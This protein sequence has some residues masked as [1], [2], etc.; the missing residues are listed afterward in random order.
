M[1]L[2]FGNYGNGIEEMQQYFSHISGAIRFEYMKADLLMAQEDLEKYVGSAVM[3]EA[4]NHYHTG[5][6]NQPLSNP[7]ASGSGSAADSL[8]IKDGLV[9]H[10]QMAVALMGYRDYALNNDATHT[11]TGRLARMDKE[12]GDEW[13]EKLIDRDDFALQRKAQRAIDRLIKYVDDNEMES[14]RNSD[15]YADTKELLLW[16]ATLFHRFHPIEYSRRL[17]MLLVPMIRSVQRDMVEPIFGTERWT[18][19]MTRMKAN[20][21]KGDGEGEE[22]LRPLYDKAGYVIAYLA[23]S[24]GYTDL[25]L[26]LFP[27]TMSRQFWSAGSGSAFVTFRQRLIDGLKEEGIHKLKLL[28]NYIRA[29]ETKDEGEDVTDDTMTTSIPDRMDTGNKFVRV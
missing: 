12:S 28:E 11:K 2:I 26:Q 24:Q 29:Q 13:T 3:E 1:K 16:N 8:A 4:I 17:Y 25:P 15:L 14:W 22:D 5:Q 23:L 6:Y 27:E 7:N 10:V 21:L 19:L 18:E 9:D 20:N